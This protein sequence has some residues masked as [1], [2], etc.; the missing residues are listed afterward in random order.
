M[1]TIVVFGA[2]GYTG[3]LVT[4]ALVARG[5]S[6][7]IAGRDATR[8]AALSQELGGLEV[9]VADVAAPASVAALVAKGDVLISTVGP[10]TRLGA[11]AV[12]AAVERGAHYLDSTGE[13][14]FI[15]AIFERHDEPARLRG[16]ALLTAFGYDYVPGHLAASLA[17]EQAPSAVGVDI[18]YFASGGD[19]FGM[20]R[21]TA[22]TVRETAFDRGLLFH[23]GRLREGAAGTRLGRFTIAGKRRV[24]V[25][26]ASSEPYVLPRCYPRLRDVSVYLGWFGKA[27]YA[28]AP[29]SRVTGPLLRLDIVRQLGQRALAKLVPRGEGDA[30]G[31]GE[32]A[33]AGA[34]SLIVAVA[35]DGRGRSLAQVELIGVNSYDYTGRILAWGAERALAGGLAGVGALGPVEAFGLTALLAGNAEAGLTRAP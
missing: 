24:G 27:A 23:R 16:V 21:G 25:E 1:G 14:A 10:F 35:R 4:E 30:L 7:R 13:G 12:A 33:R 11:P 31:P 17:L 34:G 20:S 29:L 32:D 6:P 8:L 22:A 28:M 18:G 26:V 15:R 3:R 9:Q 19:G 2:T 5:V